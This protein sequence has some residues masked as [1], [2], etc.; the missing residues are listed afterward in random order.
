MYQ[1]SENVPKYINA[2]RF[3]VWNELHGVT[4]LDLLDECHVISG[5]NYLTEIEREAHITLRRRKFDNVYGG[6]HSRY[7]VECQE[8]MLKAVNLANRKYSGAFT[9]ADIIELK[10]MYPKRT[11][12][13]KVDQCRRR[14]TRAVMR[15]VSC[16][17]SGRRSH[18]GERGA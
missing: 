11:I 4:E 10:R 15:L 12:A 1:F 9:K 8:D 18:W 6:Q 7:Y 14:L 5:R 3:I 2:Y 13:A 17:R 16:R